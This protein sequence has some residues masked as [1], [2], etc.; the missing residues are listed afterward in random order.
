[1]PRSKGK[2]GKRSGA[3][4]GGNVGG[5]HELVFKE[6]GQEYGQVTRMLGNGRLEAYCFDGKTRQCHIRGQMQ[7]KVWINVN[8]VILVSLREYEDGKADVIKKYNSDEIIQLK[9]YKEIPDRLPAEDVEE[10]KDVGIKFGVGDDISDDEINEED[11]YE[12][13]E[14]EEEEDSYEVPAQNRVYTLDDL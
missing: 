8:D 13:E 5:I 11:S 3:R 7:R 12:G 10:K 14:E 6:E 1:M 2:G 4:K 9:K